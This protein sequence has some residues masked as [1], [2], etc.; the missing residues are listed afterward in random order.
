MK[1]KEL[2]RMEK[3]DLRSHWQRE[4]THFTPWLARE[5]N[6]ALLSEAI[7]IGELEVEATEAPVGDFRVDILC[8]NLEDDTRV[9][10]ENQLEATNHSHLGQLITY[11]AGLDA[12]TLVWVVERFKEEHRAA[13]DWLNRFTGE[14]IHL[15]GLEIELWRIGDSLAAPKFNL[16]AN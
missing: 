15:F 16:V 13:L 14:E 11:A 4:D 5:E 8:R 10:I 2:G 12:V 1:S 9:V 7:G 6:L 3:V